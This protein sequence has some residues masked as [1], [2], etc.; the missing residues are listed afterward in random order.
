MKYCSHCG[1]EVM[2]DAV[3]CTKC[4]CWLNNNTMATAVQPKAKMNVCALVGFIISMVSIVLFFIDFIGLL[5]LAGMIVS[6]VGLTQL[7]IKT[8]QRGKGFA[9]AGLVVGACFFLLGVI[10]WI[11]IL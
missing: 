4:G 2:D 5:A 10:F 3:L 6:L 9:I 1:A 8:E 7:N 11:G